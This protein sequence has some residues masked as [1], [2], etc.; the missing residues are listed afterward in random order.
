MMLTESA[1]PGVSFAVPLTGERGG[2]SRLAER[3]PFGEAAGS[4]VGPQEARH[5]IWGRLI[6]PVVQAL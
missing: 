1:W 4:A 2:R 6:V 5:E 3:T